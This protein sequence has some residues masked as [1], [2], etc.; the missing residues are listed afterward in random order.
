MSCGR[1]LGPRLFPQDTVYLYDTDNCQE[2]SQIGFNRSVGSS[3]EVRLNSGF[4]SAEGDYQI[5]GKS[6]DDA[7]NVSACTE[8]SFTYTY[9]NSPPPR[10]NSISL[11]SDAV[12]AQPIISVSNLTVGNTVKIYG[13]GLDCSMLLGS[14]LA[15]STTELITLDPIQTDGLY[16][17]RATA[18]DQALNESDCSTSNTDYTL[19]QAD[20]ALTIVSIRSGGGRPV[21]GVGGEIIL[22]FTATES[23]KTQT[24]TIEGQPVSSELLSGNN[25]RA[26]YTVLSGD[27]PGSVE[28]SIDY[29]DFADAAGVSVSSTTD[30]SSI[31]IDP[32]V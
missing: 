14:K 16:N 26:I 4:I 27:N 18:T 22:S 2:T 9:D 6:S 15:S 8:F 13:D 3:V 12:P 29:T 32:Q 7:G 11:E 21:V 20:P 23:L 24:V 19:N 1:T 30:S 5:L 28:F 10:P 31:T 17:I 25:Y